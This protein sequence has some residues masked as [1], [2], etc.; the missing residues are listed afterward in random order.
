MKIKLQ[1]FIIF[2]FIITF[3]FL[4]FFSC[5]NLN[6]NKE[7]VDLYT[8]IAPV[9]FILDNITG[10]TLNTS[11]ILK[12]GSDPH[13]YEISAK[14]IASIVNSKA[15]FSI[16]LPFEKTIVEKLEKQKAKIKIY[17]VELDEG[18]DIHRWT[19]ISKVKEISEEFLKALSEIYPD[20]KEIFEKN[21]K[22]FIDKLDNLYLAIKFNID[23]SKAKTFLIVHPALTYFAEDFGLTQ[24]SIE[25][26]GKEPSLSDLVELSKIIQKE[27]IKFIFVQPEFPEQQIMQFIKDNK[28][29]TVNIDILGYNI[30][31]T[32]LKV[33]ETFVKYSK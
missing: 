32:L 11:T 13:T 8:S 19:S 25:K 9:K 15:Y 30:F 18:Q 29:E 31:D 17:K 6:K 2:T 24:Y 3:T 21:Y 10:E 22:I 7:K 28:L 12:P 5:Q 27:K 26:E 14:E 23:S 20:K 16:D 1:I 4:T 33:S